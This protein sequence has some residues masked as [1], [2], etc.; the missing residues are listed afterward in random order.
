[1]GIPGRVT[2]VPGISR[3]QQLHK[4]GNGVVPHQAYTA[5]RLILLELL[6]AERL[7]LAA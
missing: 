5:Y 6:L 4:V 2:S 3:S 7:Q 1:M